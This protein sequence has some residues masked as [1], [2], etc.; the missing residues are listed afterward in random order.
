IKRSRTGQRTC[1]EYYFFHNDY[2]LISSTD[3]SE[4]SLNEKKNKI[5]RIKQ[6]TAETFS[7]SPC[8]E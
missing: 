1:Y 8:G 2:F 4:N 6:L 7:I 5:Y 3:E